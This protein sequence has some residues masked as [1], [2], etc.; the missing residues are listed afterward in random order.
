MYGHKGAE[1]MEALSRIERSL[2]SGAD[3]DASITCVRHGNGKGDEPR[4]GLDVAHRNSNV[5]APDIDNRS[6]TA[7]V[8]GI[9][10]EKVFLLESRAQRNHPIR[11]LLVGP[12]LVRPERWAAHH[13]HGAQ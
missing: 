2:P 4:S 8:A 11:P 5:F 13:R 9:H 3:G 10:A 6:T 7:I 12:A 1:S